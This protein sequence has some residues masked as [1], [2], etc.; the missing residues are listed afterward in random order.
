[1]CAA[2][3]AFQKRKG[4]KED[5][6]KNTATKIN[7][8]SADTSVDPR[9]GATWTYAATK[10]RGALAAREG[11]PGPPIAVKRCT[12]KTWRRERGTPPSTSSSTERR[13]DGR[14]GGHGTRTLQAWA[15]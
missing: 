11:S 6:G 10:K 2:K 13:G 12:W 7:V 5:E 8:L 15:E 3:R 4:D 9:R 1:M 14:V